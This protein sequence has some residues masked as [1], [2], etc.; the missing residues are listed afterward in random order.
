M[1]LLTVFPNVVTVGAL[2][3]TMTVYGTNLAEGMTVKVGTASITDSTVSADGD[4]ITFAAPNLTVGVYPVSVTRNGKTV[5][6][7]AAV[8]YRDEGSYVQ[9]NPG[10]GA[11][12]VEMKLPLYAVQSGPLYALRAEIEIPETYFSAAGAEAATGFGGQVQ[13]N[14]QNSVLTV[15]MVNAG[16][17]TTSAAQPVAWVVLT[18]KAVAGQTTVPLTMKTAK[19]NDISVLSAPQIVSVVITP[20]YPLTAQVQYYKDNAAVPGVLISA[21]GVSGTTDAS[22]LTELAGIKTQSVTVTASREEYD[23]SAVNL[24]DVLELLKSLVGKTTLDQ[25]QQVAADVTNDGALSPDPVQRDGRRLYDLGGVY[26]RGRGPG[27]HLPRHRR[28]W[29]SDHIQL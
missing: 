11:P 29:V 9:L 12:G 10:E 25:Y 14:W 28:Q 23:E 7:P 3:D 6:L 26:L 8:T 21:A 20:S 24:L 19:L 16:G 4:Q 22:G 18:P 17:Y 1:T 15:S 5:T 2:P 27:G 13:T